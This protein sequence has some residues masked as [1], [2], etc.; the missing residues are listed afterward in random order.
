M[1][2]SAGVYLG[3]VRDALDF[4]EIV[5][6]VIKPLIFGFIVAIVGCYMGLSTD[7]RDGRGRALDD[8]LGG[9]LVDPIILSQLRAHEADPRLAARALRGAAGERECGSKSTP[10]NFTDVSLA[11]NGRRVL[12]RMSFVVRYGE[13]KI[14]MGG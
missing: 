14:V 1:N 6:G 12:N 2:Q 4:N 11:F 13:A 8:A 9:H 3:S 10:S 5:G 7:G